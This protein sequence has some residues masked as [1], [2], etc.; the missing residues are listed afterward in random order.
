M[1]EFPVPDTGNIVSLGMGPDVDSVESNFAQA[2]GR[3][4][5]R[6]IDYRGPENQLLL[7]LDNVQGPKKSRF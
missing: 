7:D 6:P 4:T 3:I 5:E 2:T 1:W